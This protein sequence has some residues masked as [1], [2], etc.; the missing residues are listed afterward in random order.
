MVSIN[1]AESVFLRIPNIT[2]YTPDFNRLYYTPSQLHKYKAKIS[3]IFNRCGI[4]ERHLQHTVWD[5]SK[6]SSDHVL[7]N[8]ECRS[9]SRSIL[10]TLH[11]LFRHLNEKNEKNS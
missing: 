7:L 6:L 8:I 1:L 5:W 3:K 11:W 9:G 10:L 2:S 4:V